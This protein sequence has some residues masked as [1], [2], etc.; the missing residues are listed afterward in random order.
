[1]SWLEEG[2][3]V[4]ALLTMGIV[5]YAVGCVA[6]WGRHRSRLMEMHETHERAEDAAYCLGRDRGRTEH[7]GLS[8]DTVAWYK[9][10]YADGE[11]AGTRR[12]QR[13][14]DRYLS[15]LGIGKQ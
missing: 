6:S 5:G 8:E 2:Y 11:R 14:V 9:K 13:R 12:E 4:G 1:M 10:G 3:L 15:E 7:P